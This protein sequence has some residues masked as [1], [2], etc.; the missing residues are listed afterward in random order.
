MLRALPGPLVKLVLS[1]SKEGAGGF[2]LTVTL[3]LSKGD[4]NKIDIVVARF[5]ERFWNSPDR[6]NTS[7]WVTSSFW[8]RTSMRAS[9]LYILDRTIFSKGG[10]LR[11]YRCS[12]FLACS[13]SSLLAGE[14]RLLFAK[15]T[16]H[17]QNSHHKAGSQINK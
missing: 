8:T 15:K 6:F 12:V 2:F 4:L 10:L 11:G 3:S 5:I 7:S 17:N 9:M 1:L 13:N 16:N 14:E